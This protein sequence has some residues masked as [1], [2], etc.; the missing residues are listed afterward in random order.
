MI[1]HQDNYII[2]GI[3]GSSSVQNPCWLMINKGILL[4]NNYIG[5]YSNLLYSIRGIPINQPGLI[6]MREGF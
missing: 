6:G 1:I 3:K 5:D 4:P 2:L